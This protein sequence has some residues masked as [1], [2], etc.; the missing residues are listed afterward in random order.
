MEVK[1]TRD[2]IG[3]FKHQ[4]R[5]KTFLK[6]TVCRPRT[7]RFGV[8][9]IVGLFAFLPCDMSMSIFG[10]LTDHEFSCAPVAA[11]DEHAAGPRPSLLFT[12]MGA[13][14]RSTTKRRQGAFVSCNSKLG[15][16]PPCIP[17]LFGYRARS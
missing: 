14:P 2:V 10:E 13:G 8:L 11:T 4:V 17:P 6:F 16:P 5:A 7:K 3:R 15:V 12:T 1:F 9:V